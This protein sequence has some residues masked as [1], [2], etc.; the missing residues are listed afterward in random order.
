VKLV[1]IAPPASEEFTEAV[2]WYEGKRPGLGREFYDAIIHA[3]T[4]VRTHPEIGVAVEGP[5][6][7]RQFLIDGFPYK[8]IYRERADDLY[9]VAVAHVSR[10]PSYWK[11]RQ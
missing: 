1:H 5:Y 4:V 2:Q 9:I 3:A 7:Y 10:R 6:Q 11:K 8:L